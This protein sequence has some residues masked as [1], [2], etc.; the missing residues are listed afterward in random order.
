MNEQL[1]A[2][3]GFA[4]LLILC[5][6]FAGTRKLVLELSCWAL[7]L[8]LLALLAGGAV[9]F[10]RPDLMPEVVPATVAASPWLQQL[11][12]W[13]GSPLFG[14][15]AAVLVAAAL[16]PLL[17]VLDVTRQLA[18]GRLRRLRRLADQAQ[19]VSPVAPPTV[20]A[21]APVEPRVEEL[22]VA[23]PVYRRPGRQASAATL[24]EIGA[25]KPFRIADHVS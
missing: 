10:F 13:P 3:A 21:V 17:A 15:T 22:P 1:L 6:P 5:L 20:V 14:L 4:L 18:G 16:L 8:G 24:A 2:W 12:P 23:E 9:L 11:L 25:R 19:Y 7:R